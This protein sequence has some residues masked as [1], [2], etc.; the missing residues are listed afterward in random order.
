MKSGHASFST[1]RTRLGATTWT[2]FTF[3]LSRRADAPLYRSNV[4]FTSSA[5]TAVVELRVLA[6]DELVGEPVLGRR[7]R[8]GQAR[9]ADVARHRLHERVVQ[10][11]EHHEGCDQRFGVAGVEPARDQ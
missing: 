4:N 8:L 2:S 9:R 3:S 5:V 1:K 6:Q 11:V 10:R 7:P